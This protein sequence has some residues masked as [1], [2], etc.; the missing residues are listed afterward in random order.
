MIAPRPR[1]TAMQKTTIARESENLK[2]MACPEGTKIVGLFTGARLR[3]I[4]SR[5]P[6]I[7]HGQVVALVSADSVNGSR[8]DHDGSSACSRQSEPFCQRPGQAVAGPV[9]HPRH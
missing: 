8:L 3:I 4:E 6:C 9:C 1:M 7:M 5:L 2:A